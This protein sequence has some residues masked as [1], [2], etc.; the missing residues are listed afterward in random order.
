MDVNPKSTGKKQ[1]HLKDIVV[2]KGGDNWPSAEEVIKEEYQ[3]GFRE[4]LDRRA[5]EVRGFRI[6]HRI[7]YQHPS[8]PKYVVETHNPFNWYDGWE[9]DEYLSQEHYLQVERLKHED[10]RMNDVMDAIEQHA[11][12]IV[13]ALETV[14]GSVDE[15]SK[16]CTPLEYI[17][18]VAK[19]LDRIGERLAD[20]H[21]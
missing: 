5:A 12:N 3:E 4:D 18:D 17:P 10:K 16:N 11:E 20:L 21:R 15:I 8:E 9:T 7:F 6:S 13:D 14:S 2:K 1:T 19:Q